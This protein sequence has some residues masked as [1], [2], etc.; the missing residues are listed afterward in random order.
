MIRLAI[1]VLMTMLMIITG[2]GRS[3]NPVTA[4]TMIEAVLAASR[5]G[6]FDAAARHFEGGPKRFQTPIDWRRAFFDR[7]SDNGNAQT[8]TVRERQE[9]GDTLKLHITTYSDEEMKQ[10]LHRSVWSFAKS[11]SGWVITQVE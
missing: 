7:I 10:P 6:D 8:F 3:A 11:K 4:E 1:V 2:C 9:S 5:E